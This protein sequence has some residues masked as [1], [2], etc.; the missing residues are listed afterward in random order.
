MRRR[1]KE[2]KTIEIIIAISVIIGVCLSLASI[3]TAETIE[4]GIIKI[5]STIMAVLLFTAGGYCMC[6]FAWIKLKKKYDL[7]KL[8]PFAQNSTEEQAQG[9]NKKKNTLITPTEKKFKEHLHQHLPTNVEIHCMVRLYDILPDETQEKL[10]PRTHQ[11]HFQS[12]ID[13]TLVIRDTQEIILAIELD[14]RSHHR[15]TAIENDTKK[16]EILKESEVCLTRVPVDRM[17]DPIT[18]KKI[19]KFCEEKI[20]QSESKKE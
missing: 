13:F 20:A 18:I 17:Y 3:Q 6:Y 15:K 1:K 2:D 19:V 14:D 9:T 10:T 11:Y 16:N 5:I 12:H 4:G 8:F 7:D